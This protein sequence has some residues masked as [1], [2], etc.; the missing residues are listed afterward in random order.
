[1]KADFSFPFLKT[2]NVTLAEGGC[3]NENG[4]VRVPAFLQWIA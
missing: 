4:S 1:M 2:P 3:F